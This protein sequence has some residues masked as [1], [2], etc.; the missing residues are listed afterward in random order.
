M[1]N[2]DGVIVGN[3]RCSLAGVDLNRKWINPN[4]KN[5]PEVFATKAMFEKTLKSRKIFF[6]V[7]C[8][9]HSRKK[10]VFMFGC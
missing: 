2:P 9:G 10:N 4:I 7:D 6:Y 8:H 3:Y 1:L 5:L